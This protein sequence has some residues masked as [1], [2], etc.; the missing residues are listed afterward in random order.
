MSKR[1][2]HLLSDWRVGLSVLL[3]LASVTWG[4][5]TFAGGGPVIVYVDAAAGGAND[6]SSWADAYTN[7]QTALTGAGSG[8]QIWVARGTYTPGGLRTSTFQL[9]DNVELYGGFP[10]GGGDGT[11]DVRDPW[12]YTTV[13]SGEIGD[14]GLKTDNVYHVVTGS[15]TDSSALL[16]GFTIRDGYANGPAPH[17]DGAGVYAGSGSPTLNNVIFTANTASGDGGGLYSNLGSPTLNN[18]TFEG[19]SANMG[20]GIYGIDAYLAL[21]D[22]LFIGNEAPFGGGIYG[23]TSD[24]YLLNVV[25]TG[26][27]ATYGGGMYYLDSDPIL[28]NVT[29]AGNSATYGGGM[30]NYTDSDPTLASCIVWGNAATY[31]DQLYNDGTSTPLISYS[32]LEGCG[33]SGGGWNTACGIDSGGNIDADP[34][35]VDPRPAGDT[36]T[37]AGDYHL[38]HDSPAIDAGDSDNPYLGATDLDGRGRRFDLPFVADSGDGAAPMV[39][40]GAYEAHLIYV[41]IDATAGSDDGTSWAD[42][43]LALQDGLGAVRP[44]DEVWVAEGVYYPDLGAGQ[45]A[46][47]VTATFQLLDDVALYGGFEATETVREARDWRAHVTI[48]S[49][50]LDQNDTT[51]LRGLVVDTDQITGTNAC[52]VVTGSGVTRTA[53]LDGFHVTAGYA[54]WVSEIGNHLGGGMYNDAGSPTVR[55]VVFVGNK[56]YGGG[57]MHN[58]NGSNPLVSDV[59]LIGNYATNTGGGMG[60][61]QSSPRL[62]N[63]AFV[64]NTNRSTGGGGMRNGSDSDPTMTNVLFSGNWSEHGRGGGLLNSIGSDPTLVNVTFAGNRAHFPGGALAND[65]SNPTLINCVLWGNASDESDDEIYNEGTSTPTISY[66]DVAGSGGSGG[67]WDTSLGIAAGGNVD[68]A[69]QFVDPRPAGD[70][71]TTAAN[72]HL[73]PT[74]PVIDAGDNSAVTATTDL[75]GGPRTLDVALVTDTGNGTAPFVDMGAYEAHLIY[76]DADATAGSD[77]GT[78]WADAYLTLQD[79]LSE[80]VA[81]DEVWVAEGI[82]YTD[83]GGG[84]SDDDFSATFWVPDGVRLYGGFDGTETA[85]E[86]RDW[87][88]EITVLSG[89][90]EQN[91]DT[92]ANGVVIDS[93]DIEHR[94]SDHVVT[95]EFVNHN[96]VLDGFTITAGGAVGPYPANIGA[97][98]V[99]TGGN[100]T[101]AHVTFSGN[102]AAWYGGGL[103]SEGDPI[104][105]DVIFQGGYANTAGG[106]FNAAGSN[107]ELTNVVFRD[108]FAFSSGGMAAWENSAPRLTAVAFLG[109][110]ASGEGGGMTHF[111]GSTAELINVLFAGNKAQ[112]GGG[113]YSHAG[114][115]PTLLNVTLSGNH[116]TEQGGGLFNHS[117]T[118]LTNSVL[119]GNT[120]G[121]TGAQI[122]NSGVYPMIRY[123]D[124]EGSGGSG[125]G[126]DMALGIDGGGNIDAD[127]QFVDPQ[128]ASAAPTVAG[129]YRLRHDSPAADAGDNV[130]VFGIA[131][132][133]DGRTRREDLPS[134]ADTGNGFAPLVD[135]GTYEARVLYVKVGTMGAD[136]GSSWEDA[137]TDL[138]DALA[139]ALG[140]DE[141]WV[142]EG[143]YVPSH[144]EPPDPTVSFSLIDHVALYG[145]FV[146]TETSRQQRDWEAHLTILS[147]DLDHDDDRDANG[148]VTDTAGISGTNAY[149]VVTGSGVTDTAVLDGF[150]VTGGYASDPGCRD[151][152]AGAYI[153]EARPTLRNLLFSGNLAVEDGGGM[154][155]DR[156][157]PTLTNVVFSGNGSDDDGGGLY[158]NQGDPTLTNVTFSDNRAA[159]VGGGTYSFSGAPSLT[160]VT[161]S[162]NVANAGGGM[163]NASSHPSLSSTIFLSNTSNNAGG[164]MYNWQS[165]PALTNLVFNGN[166]TGG[167]GGAVYNNVGNPTLVNVTFSANHA[168]AEGGVMANTLD[169]DPSLTNCILWGNT[170]TNGEQI[171]NVD[172]DSAPTLSY[173]LVEGGCPSGSTCD[174]LLTADPEFADAGGADGVPGTSDDDLHL[175]PGSPAIDAGDNSAVPGGV[176]TDLEGNPRFFD[177]VTVPDTGN[178]T[179]PI[180]DLGAYE[181]NNTPPI[182]DAGL[183]QTTSPGDTV[184]LDG[185]GSSDP[186]GHSLSYWW[187]QTGGTAVTLSDAGAISPT[188]TAPTTPGVLTFTLTVT[189]TFGLADSDVTTVEIDITEAEH[190]IYLPLVMRAQP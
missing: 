184:S 33:G 118:P 130:P 144:E 25:A 129:N 24:L 99:N 11:M 16:D 148:V 94:N 103:W 151:S 112:Y 122:R 60:N 170:A 9:K 35:F 179:P 135:M 30:R 65:D 52:H 145:G 182:A 58:R 74:S 104:L 36:P 171:H 83:E 81:G 86:D 47:S 166:S 146:G 63:V 28:T 34:S 75:D 126:W 116:A 40:M 187:Q 38:F 42:A 161:F 44:G 92:D 164:G 62:V 7:L 189:D 107:P 48:L 69:P 141:I 181:T 111:D 8:T 165:D 106:M 177:V 76:V 43:F 114:S 70:A 117:A 133:L 22:A 85:R 82:Y 57:G 80:T 183:P 90:I 157:D 160:D 120:A 124:I 159:G 50:D 154:Y 6:G 98:M 125:A 101:L 180:I 178:G 4:A 158:N 137:F 59:S 132:D 41:D 19:N 3:V 73:S 115:A 155:N 168:G 20:G 119:W 136:D 78:S 27:E 17:D 13:L 131:T 139:S 88:T 175:A 169:S 26:N 77:D 167:D 72:N 39:D 2:K 109:N 128:P 29:I 49:G 186:D 185:S 14:P 188:F 87:E 55:Y 61:W 51:D 143:V 79:A 121:V 37:T 21:T 67:S 96:T 163:Y 174:H 31:G 153:Y 95:T 113:M 176:T 162:G 71:P 150:I 172:V 152:G 91:D 105:T 68:V 156:G 123:C 56:A 10:P 18:V 147:G 53:T 173:S 23:R 32:D 1:Y 100:P 127:P 5:P 140:G 45:I 190:Y 84:Q 12:T 138:Q 66:S 142:A 64:G 108:N 54:A 89:D 102:H 46:D 110:E 15:G 134:M 149:H 93:D 97:G